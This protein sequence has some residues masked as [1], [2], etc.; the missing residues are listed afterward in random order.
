MPINFNQ[1]PYY[2]DWNEDNLYHRLLFQPGRAVQA[3][4]LTQIQ[5]LLQS[6]ISKLGSHIFKDGS[7]V[8]GG[9]L[10]YDRS[11]THWLAVK[12]QDGRGNSVR[13]RDISP[14][15]LI[16]KNAEAGGTGT[17]VNVI[18]RV[19]NVI[20]SENDDPDTIYFKWLEGESIGFNAEENVVFC[21]S[22]SGVTR[23][24]A[25]TLDEDSNGARHYGT[26]S[27][28]SVEPGI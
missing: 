17:S 12:P 11:T 14:G 7:A 3:R 15:M 22:A 19:G 24:T 8:V 23:Y 18:G 26:A 28:L 5:S 1:Y 2:D 13:V 9:N 4:E 10:V 16:K 27:T 6:Q 25:T 21:D 20:P